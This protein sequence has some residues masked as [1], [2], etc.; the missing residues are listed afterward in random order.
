M[1]ASGIKDTD[2]Q[3]FKTKDFSNFQVFYKFFQ[4]GDFCDVTLIADN[5]KK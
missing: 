2:Q 5:G 1:E 3:R 4:N